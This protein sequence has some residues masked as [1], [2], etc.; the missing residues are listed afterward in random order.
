MRAV[1]YAPAEYW[2][3]DEKQKA[4]MTNGCGPGRFGSL[5]VPDK[6]LWLDI[7]EACRI[8]DWCY[9]VGVTIEDKHEADRV[10]L[11]NMLRLIDARM[12]A[13]PVRLIRTRMA[14]YYYHAVR[15][16]GGPA[17]WKG[18]NSPATLGTV[19]V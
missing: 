9:A 2:D 3:L 17:F 11:N 13:W 1:L 5:V 16:L 8:H 15:D 7:S 18:K 6:L 12:S 10:F 19:Q 4:D 14:T